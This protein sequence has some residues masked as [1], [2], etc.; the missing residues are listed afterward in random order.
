LAFGSGDIKAGENFPQG[1]SVRIFGLNPLHALLPHGY[2]KFRS[3][4]RRFV[5]LQP[6]THQIRRFSPLHFAPVLSLWA[7][8]G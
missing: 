4:E 6:L 8:G 3:Y 2:P 1:S 7:N 5:D